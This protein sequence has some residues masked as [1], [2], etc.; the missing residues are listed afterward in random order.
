MAMWWLA[1]QC[2]TT[3]SSSR[4]DAVSQN[5]WL[6]GNIR[7]AWLFGVPAVLF[8]LIAFVGLVMA[9]TNPGYQIVWWTLAVAAGVVAVTLGIFAYEATEP[10][11]Q[12]QN[13]F[14]LVHLSPFRLKRIPLDIVECFFSGSNS[15]DAY[16]ITTETDEPAYR[17]GTVVIRLAERASEYRA[18]SMFS[19]WGVWQDSS[20]ILD[21]RWCEPLSPAL[22]KD[23]ASR[24][25]KAKQDAIESQRS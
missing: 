15:L 19:P 11:L 22:L 17:V 25:M 4:E 12:C 8:G 5:V 10:R 23:L 9:F 18:G 24:L 20:I 21:G 6:H 13:G 7:F 3:R 1:R 16:G 14:L 2:W